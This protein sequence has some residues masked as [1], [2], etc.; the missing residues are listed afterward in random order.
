MVL[1]HGLL[2]GFLVWVE[3]DGFAVLVDVILIG[4]SVFLSDSSV[5]DGFVVL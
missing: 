4:W 5:F 2:Y 3:F 1:W